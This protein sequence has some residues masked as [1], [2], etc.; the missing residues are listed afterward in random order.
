MKN[1]ILHISLEFLCL[2][3]AVTE[4][5]NDYLY[6][7]QFTVHTDNNPLTYVLSTAKLDATG[8]RW[9][10]YLS[11]FNFITVLLFIYRSG[12]S[13]GDADGLSRKPQDTEEIFPDV[14]SVVCQ[15]LTV[16]RD[17]CPLAETLI[18]T[19]TNSVLDSVESHLF[20]FY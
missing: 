17:N 15:A 4:K 13:N 6:G 2:K 14:V 10:A 16:E 12:E 1:N 9:L 7:N 19:N 20:R 3:W 18:F 11:N 5:F 8:H